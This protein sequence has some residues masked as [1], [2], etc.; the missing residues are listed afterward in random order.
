MSNNKKELSPKTQYDLE[1]AKK[2]IKRVPLDMQKEEYDK[3]KAAAESSGEKVNAYIK[4]AIRER[5][6]RDVIEAPGD[7]SHFDRSEENTQG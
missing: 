2:N 7:T 4:R 6:E 5:M 1:Y 3:L